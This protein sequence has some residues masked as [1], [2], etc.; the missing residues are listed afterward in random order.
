MGALANIPRSAKLGDRLGVLVSLVCG[1][2]CAAMTAL[3]ILY[4]ALWLNHQFWEIGLWQNLLRLERVF[5]LLAWLFAIIAMTP[6]IVRHQRFLAPALAMLGLALLTVAITSPLHNQ[7]ILG[8]S[9]AL[10]GGL[11]LASAHTLNLFANRNQKSDSTPNN[12]RR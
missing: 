1:L 10:T 3:F 7:P 2:H 6:A 11:L 5:L 4:P 9:L 12:Q 8:S